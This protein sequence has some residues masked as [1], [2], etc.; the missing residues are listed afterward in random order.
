MSNQIKKIDSR[1]ADGQQVVADLMEIRALLTQRDDLAAEVSGLRKEKAA[2]DGEVGGLKIARDTASQFNNS[3]L[4]AAS[5]V[6][7]FLLA[8]Q[9]QTSQAGRAKVEEIYLRARGWR[10]ADNVDSWRLAG[11]SP[12]ARATAIK[13]QIQRDTTTSATLMASLEDRARAALGYA[14]LAKAAAA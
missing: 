14:P 3:A 12:Q 10:L 1:I 4:L 9:S 13:L 5:E 11:A 2:L 6:A 8:M 7:A